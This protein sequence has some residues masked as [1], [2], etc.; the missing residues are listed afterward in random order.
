LLAVGLL[1]L[2]QSIIAY[3]AEVELEVNTGATYDTNVSRS[4]T[5][6]RRDTYFTMAPRLALKLPFNKAYFSSDVR[7]AAEQ[8]VRYANANLQELVFSGLGRYNTSDYMSFGLQDRLIISG[9]L[10]SAEKLTDVTRWR[11]FVDNS[12]LFVLKRD[13]EGGILTTSLE[14]ENI[15]RDYSG[16]EK[17][18]W[19]L[20]NGR[21]HIEYF[22]GNRTSTQVEFG[23]IRKFYK[24]DVHYISIP[25]IASLKRKL[26]S[27]VDGNLLLGFEARR[28]DEI[29]DYLNWDKLTT[30][31]EIKGEFTAKTSSTLLLQRKVHDSD[32]IAGRSF[33]STAVD[34]AVAFNLSYNTQLVLQGLYS[35]NS[36]ILFERRDNVFG[37]RGTIE[38]RLSRWGAIVLGYGHER[39]TS[40][41]LTRDYK[42]HTV[43]LYYVALL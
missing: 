33:V 28:Y 19:M 35:K 14:Y 41:V 13:L 21:L 18:D 3:A 34:V 30:S 40:N 23:L 7:A 16:T 26:S 29:C 5:D 37:G 27:K 32:L 12:F 4:V 11:Q 1:T 25:L 8:H 10:K 36:Y 20:H 22:F 38:Y 6:P 9:R 2:W 43:D 15:I 39:R 24:V 42:Q 31:L 17:D